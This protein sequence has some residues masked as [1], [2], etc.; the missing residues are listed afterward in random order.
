LKRSAREELS[1]VGGNP[2]LQ[3]MM[4]RYPAIWE[5]TGKELVAALESGKTQ[6]FVAGTQ[7]N[8]VTWEGRVRASGRNTRVLE[9]ALPFIIKAKMA[10]RAVEKC[11]LAAATG[12]AAG[13]TRFRWMNGFI[14]QKL[15]FSHDLVRKPVSDGWFRFWWRMVGQKR[16]LMPLVQPRGIFCFYSR[17]LVRELARLIGQRPAL[18][19]AAG[20]GTLSRFLQAEGVPIRATDNHSWKAISYSA[21]VER[22]DAKEALHRYEPGAVVCS[23]PPPGNSFERHVFATRSVELYVVIGSRYRFASGAWDAYSAQDR[24]E[25][26]MDPRLGGFVLP[27]EL[28]SAVLVFRRLKKA[29]HRETE[30][31]R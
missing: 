12:Q 28:E 6:E 8:A 16:L 29:N 22:L 7:A 15:L 5:E 26:G 31:Q 9:S 1:W 25:W 18:E 19:I 13:K 23:W 20:D 14:L 30:A 17:A 10:R 4:D 24:F 3:Q 21:A 27:P 2:S 11:Y